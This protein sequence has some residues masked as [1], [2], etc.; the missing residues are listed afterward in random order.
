[1][2][3]LACRQQSLGQRRGVL[4]TCRDV[5]DM[6]CGGRTAF[7]LSASPRSPAVPFLPHTMQYRSNQHSQASWAVSQCFPASVL[8]KNILCFSSRHSH[9]RCTRC[10]FLFLPACYCILWCLCG[11]WRTSRGCPVTAATKF[12]HLKKSFNSSLFGRQCVELCTS[13]SRGI[14]PNIWKTA[15]L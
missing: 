12:A 11:R 2:M 4:C 15:I 5:Y 3:Q 1:M 6:K 8:W 14:K 13:K 9:I 7:D 10:D